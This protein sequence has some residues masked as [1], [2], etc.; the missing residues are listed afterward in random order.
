[1][2]TRQPTHPKSCEVCSNDFVGHAL[3]KYCSSRCVNRSRE[4]RR[5]FPC[6]VCGRMMWNAHAVAPVPMCQPCRREKA[7]LVHREPTVSWTCQ[8][9]G[10]SCSRPL[11]RGQRPKWCE[12]CRNALRDR[13]IKISV[14]ARIGIYVRDGWKCWLCEGSVDRTLIGSRSI[15][16]PSL[17]HV[18]PR[19]KGGGDGDMNI[20]LA[21]LWCNSVRSDG[22]S[23]SPEDFRV[24]S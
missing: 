11:T 12:K 17:D 2:A 19:S 18:V 20:R 24:A 4:M 10:V 23:Y 15:W 13:S 16:R 3:S 7:A 1:M 22:R 9:C 14:E 6:S 21:H 5:M 8:A